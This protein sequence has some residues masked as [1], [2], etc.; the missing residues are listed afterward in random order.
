MLQAL[1]SK[2]VDGAKQKA[3]GVPGNHLSP[4]HGAMCFGF[5]VFWLRDRVGMS[6]RKP[7]ILWVPFSFG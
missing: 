3:N 2:N 4:N 5:E 7:A 1:L 6:P